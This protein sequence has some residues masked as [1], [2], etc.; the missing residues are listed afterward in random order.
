MTKPLSKL[1]MPSNP[2]LNQNELVTP[3]MVNSASCILLLV[4]RDLKQAG[5][6]ISFKLKLIF[7][8]CSV[9]SIFFLNSFYRKLPIY[10][11]FHFWHKLPPFSLWLCPCF[12]FSLFSVD[13]INFSKGT[14]WLLS[15]R[16]FAFYSKAKHLLLSHLSLG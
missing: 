15:E 16:W 4:I 1:T 12:R 6:I 11:L 13:I 3:L 9:F 8:S 14:K 10:F 7:C 5:N 2:T